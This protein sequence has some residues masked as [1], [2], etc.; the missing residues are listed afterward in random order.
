MNRPLTILVPVYNEA[1]NFPHLWEELKSAVKSEYEVVV[2]YDFDEDDTVPVVRR[3]IEG[4]A[5]NLRLIK[6]SIRRGVVGAICTGFDTVSEGPVL[7]VMADLSDDLAVVDQMLELYGRG[8]RLVA[9][10]RYMPG[11]K[12]IGGPALKKNLSRLAGLSLHWLRGIPTRDATNAFKLYDAALLRTIK[13]E[14]TAGFEINLEITVKAFLAG[15][16]IVE[17]PATWRDRTYGKSRFRLWAWLPRYL[18][19]YFLAFQSRNSEPPHARA[20]S[21]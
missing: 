15:W 11:G 4:G 9:A 2:V 19:W 13:I 17:I 21:A 18:K 12:I 1:E 16:P 14:S 5:T 10:S 20:V 7:V 8:F 3:F 6:N